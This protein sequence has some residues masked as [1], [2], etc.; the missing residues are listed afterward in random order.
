MQKIN[1]ILLV[2]GGHANIQVLHSLAKSKNKS[3]KVTLVSDVIQAPYSGMI[4]SYLSGKYLASD[5]QFDLS[6]L[7]M[8]FGFQFIQ[9]SLNLIHAESNQVQLSN[10]DL[11]EYDICSINIGIESN[12]IQTDIDIDPEIDKQKNII[13]LKPISKLI[14][15]WDQIKNFL[16][17]TS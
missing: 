13:Y 11:I 6:K 2:G 5:L 15:R 3:F 16:S 12:R 7:C 4:P 9:A 17:E 10:G 14:E 8:R 1:H